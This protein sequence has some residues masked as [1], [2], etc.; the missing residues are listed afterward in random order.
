MS[1][2]VLIVDDDQE[3]ARTLG[4]LCKREGCDV[5]LAG[6]GEEAV[7]RAPL[8][9][10]ELVLCDLHLPGIDGVETLRRLRA[11]GRQR[12]ILILTAE[13][14]VATAVEA[15]KR[16]A[17]DYLAKSAGLEE[18]QVKLRRAIEVASVKQRADALA[19]R[20]ASAARP[21]IGDHPSM[22]LVRERISQVA[23]VPDTPV[24][25]L[26]ENGTG[27]ELVATAVHA[28]SS[29]RDRPF[30]AV[31]CAAIPTELLESEFFGH[32]KGAFTGADKQ[33]LGVIELAGSGTLFLD[34]IGEMAPALQAK[35][36]RVL[37]QREYRR[38]GGS[39]T[40]RFEARLLAATNRDLQRE[41]AAGRFREDLYYRMA[42][43][44]IQLP[45]LRERLTDLPLLCEGMVRDLGRS[46]GKPVKG[47]SPEA[48]DAL[49]GYGF[50]G[51]VRELRNL[52][53]RAIIVSS[54]EWL[55]PEDLG[56]FA[57]RSADSPRPAPAAP[58]E[59]RVL[60]EALTAAGGNKA[61]AA[62]ALG[63][64]RFTLLRRLK[65]TQ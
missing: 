10:A 40:L 55:R 61:R 38:V 32:D 37:E 14:S 48:L 11:D 12:L 27:K 46:L 20:A 22:R 47:V 16:G 29:R 62:A 64:S 57:A 3:F 17:F 33:R 53:E 21:L 25:I 18:L 4:R 1:V 19:A 36:L 30:V 41:I 31:N 13:P 34:E 60:A 49:A 24:L 8:V 26:G 23:A 51:N 52:I 15:L 44:P 35:L 28:Q 54:T 42:V 59:D 5:T 56:P 6:S 45:A 9:S 39:Q 2:S 58:I 43:F 65:Q 7:E 50:P 63:I